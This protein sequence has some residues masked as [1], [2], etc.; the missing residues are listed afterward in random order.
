MEVVAQATTTV[1]HC[2]LHCGCLPPFGVRHVPHSQQ[3]IGMA[4]IVASAAAAAAPGEVPVEHWY[5]PRR[6]WYALYGLRLKAHRHNQDG[7]DED[8]EE[9]MSPLMLLPNEILYDIMRRCGPYALG[10]SACVCTRLLDVVRH[11]EL[12]K[13]ACLEAWSTTGSQKLHALVKRGYNSDWKSMWI[14]KPRLR[15]DGVYVS[16]NTY[17]KTGIAEWRVK[18][19]VHMVCYYRYIRFFSDGQFL[20][21]TT[22]A[23]LCKVARR[24]KALPVG[25]PKYA[26]EDSV[27][28]GR[29]YFHNES[30]YTS[31][32]YPGNHTTEIRSKLRLRSTAPARNNRLDILSL[33]SYIRADERYIPMDTDLDEDGREDAQSH[34]RGLTT[35]VFVPWHQINTSELNLGIDKMDYFC[36]G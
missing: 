22:P 8:E 11:P 33:M 34:R 14:H 3:R 32:V 5:A 2:A 25:P 13:R 4:T 20:Y 15:Y 29:Y 23:P 30:V 17:I 9:D 1:A 36:T 19:P 35:Y 6:P 18:N 10:A 21:K 27:I 12:W 16:R 7:E 31:M 28:L 26:G 24:L